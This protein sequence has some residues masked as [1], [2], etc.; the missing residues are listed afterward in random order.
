MLDRFWTGREVGGQR[1]RPRTTEGTGQASGGRWNC[2]AVSNW[3]ILLDEQIGWTYER[4]ML[5]Y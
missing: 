3:E 4:Y 1:E 5:G 2:R